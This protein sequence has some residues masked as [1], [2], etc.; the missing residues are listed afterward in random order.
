MK[1]CVTEKP[2]VARDIARLLGANDRH[3]G[4]FEGNGYQVT[5]T[6]GHLC[7]LK[8]PNDYTDQWKWWSLGQLPMIPQR[9]GI[10]LKDDKGIKQQFNV[11]QTLIAGAEEVISCGD[12]GQEGELIQRWVYQKAGCDKPVKRLWI[13]SLTDESIRKGF[14]QLKDA[15]DFDNLYFAGL[16]RAIGDWIL[17]MNAT[18]LYTLKYSQSRDVLSVGRVQTPTLAMIVA[19]QRE[20][21]NFVPEDYWELKTNY[22]SVI[23]NSTRGRFKTEGE[24][25]AI[26]ENIKQLPL[27]VTS[28]ETKKGKEA[29]PRL[30]DLTSLQVECNKKFG[31]SADEALKTIQSLYEKKATTYPRVDTTYLSDDIYPQVPGILRAMAPY[32]NVTAPLLSLNKL[33]K[34]KKV[35][36]NSK[37][38]DHHAI[39][40]TNVNPATVAMTPEEKRVYHLIA[41]RFIAAF[42]PDCEFNTTTV[43]AEVGDYGFKATG[44][45]IVKQGWRE[46][47]NKP[48]EKST[49]EDKEKADDEDNGIMPHFEKGESGPHEPSVLKRTTQP[50]K[51]YTEGTLLRAMETAGK[52]V[53]DEEL[54][55]AMKEN[56]IGRP[57][58]RAA[59]IETLFKRRY[60]R[61]ERKS[62]APTLAGIQ[63]IDTIHEPLLKSASLTGLWEKK[64]REIER[65]EYSA[66]QFIDE[67]KKMIGEI[68]LNVLRDN[69]SGS[70]AVE[71][72]KPTKPKAPSAAGEGKVKKQRKRL[73][74]IEEISCPVCGKGHLVKG[75]TAYG[76]SEYKNG[77]HTVMPFTEYPADL[78]PAKLS[79]MVKKNFK[80]K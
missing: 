4:Y 53:D 14:E 6:F 65:G 34:T 49:D 17:G 51:P 23:F 1:V 76:C 62:I 29:P 25:S 40:P 50:P 58:T 10:K 31:M 22:R 18:R 64:L 61:K 33:P 54:R 38:T 67:L 26:V 63:L 28:V 52:T 78:T 73:K 66:T 9:F 74:S 39:I 8:E 47:F 7:E 45:E 3:D 36:D 56:G 24:A 60:I 48:G 57:S 13:S 72:G 27:T 68:V 32:A 42:Y 80:T 43:M 70:I 71:Q 37:V 69:R 35:F 2:S 30:F 5:W 12:A 44:K 41:I 55:D 59:I 11:I 75:K 46:L 20:I 19:R 21:E 16:S 15:K 79:T 77:C